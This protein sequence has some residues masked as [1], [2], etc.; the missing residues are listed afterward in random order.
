MTIKFK[1]FNL[2]Q[3]FRLQDEPIIIP[4]K[5]TIAKAG[6]YLISRDPLII[7]RH[8][9]ANDTRGVVYLP[10]ARGENVV[11]QNLLDLQAGDNLSMKREKT[12]SLKEKIGNLWFFPQPYL[13]ARELFGVLKENPE[14]VL[15][16]VDGW[17]SFIPPGILGD[18][19]GLLRKLKNLSALTG[20]V[21]LLRNEPDLAPFAQEFLGEF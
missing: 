9:L 13:P 20:A 19:K 3:A 21:F 4:D 10:E 12:L 5:D 2:K 8:F 11:I 6:L 1:N 15:V 16:V 14:I 7:I 17:R 18:L